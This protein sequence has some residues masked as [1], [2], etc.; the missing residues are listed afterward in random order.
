[1]RK[2]QKVITK[3]VLLIVIVLSVSDSDASENVKWIHAKTVSA[4]LHQL[5]IKISLT[6]I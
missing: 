1:M 3:I 2:K 4:K 6:R 5:E